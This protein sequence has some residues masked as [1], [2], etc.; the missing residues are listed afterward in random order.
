MCLGTTLDAKFNINSFLVSTSNPT[1]RSDF[2]P[3]Q[4]GVIYR[5]ALPLV[6][7]FT[8][9]WRS[10]PVGD[11]I[12]FMT[13]VA[14]RE[15]LENLSIELINRYLKLNQV[16]QISQSDYSKIKSILMEK[17]AILMEKQAVLMEK[18]A[19]LMEK[20]KIKGNKKVV[21]QWKKDNKTRVAEHN[22]KAY[23]KRK[24]STQDLLK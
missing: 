5:L 9:R 6:G 13:K 24:A 20:A 4:R 7:N 16:S 15:G 2:T 23:Q 17:T 22:K 10:A 1:F 19:V 14:H 11:A 18:T 12:R 3:D 21:S 8:T